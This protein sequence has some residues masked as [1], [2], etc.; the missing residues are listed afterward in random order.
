MSNNTY[1][2]E[3]EN[4]NIVVEQNEK[5]SNKASESRLKQYLNRINKSKEDTVC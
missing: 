3:V 4:A 5:I 1:M 2:I